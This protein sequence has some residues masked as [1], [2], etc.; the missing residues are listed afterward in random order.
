MASRNWSAGLDQVADAAELT[1]H[2]TDN[3][4]AAAGFKAAAA[5]INTGELGDGP[6]AVQV[7]G[8]DTDTP[9]NAR[10]LTI[11]VNAYNRPTA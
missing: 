2:K 6:Y 1:K 9:G 4:R 10:T 3:K 5:I 11:T 7:S 8:V